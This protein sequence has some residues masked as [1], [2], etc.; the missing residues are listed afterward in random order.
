[1]RD[2][3]VTATVSAI[4]RKMETSHSHCSPLNAAQTKIIGFLVYTVVELFKMP[5]RACRLFKI[6]EQIAFFCVRGI[7]FCI[8]SLK[9]EPFVHLRAVI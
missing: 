5:L 1:L 8:H 3:P 2:V 6:T 4:S 7:E 9:F